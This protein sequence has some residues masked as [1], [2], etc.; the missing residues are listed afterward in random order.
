MKLNVTDES[1]KPVCTDD[2]DRLVLLDKIVIDTALFK[3]LVKLALNAPDLGGHLATV[4]INPTA[5]VTNEIMMTLE[6]SDFLFRL[7]AALRACG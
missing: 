4:D 5:T 2:I 3:Q 6:P 7:D 1:Q